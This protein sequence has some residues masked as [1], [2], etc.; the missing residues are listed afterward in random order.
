MNPDPAVTPSP[1]RTLRESAQLSQM[2]LARL[3]GLSLYAV[4]RIESGAELNP[5]LNTL[6]ALATALG[7]S[8]GELVDSV[9]PETTDNDTTE[10]Q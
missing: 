10:E 7:V 9:S 1:I 4:Q 6:R 5:K 2:D 3:T 8:V